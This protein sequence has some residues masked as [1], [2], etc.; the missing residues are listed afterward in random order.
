[1]YFTYVKINPKIVATKLFLEVNKKKNGGVMHYKKYL[2]RVKEKHRKQRSSYLN[3]FPQHKFRE[4]EMC[5]RSIRQTN[6]QQG[7]Y[8]ESNMIKAPL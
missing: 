5:S 1:M 2:D 6:D 4:F 8:I 3:I 7:I